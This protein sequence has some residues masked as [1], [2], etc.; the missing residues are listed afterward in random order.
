METNDKPIATMVMFNDYLYKTD[1]ERLL[2]AF[3]SKK[4]VKITT[5]GQTEFWGF[6]F[7]DIGNYFAYVKSPFGVYCSYIE[8]DHISIGSNRIKIGGFEIEIRQDPFRRA[9]DVL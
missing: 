8:L 4:D 9:K 2:N 6:M 3:Q 1:A 7:T 5:P